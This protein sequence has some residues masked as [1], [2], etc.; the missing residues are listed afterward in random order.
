MVLLSST[1]LVVPAVAGGLPQSPSAQPARTAASCVLEAEAHMRARRFD[2]AI[3]AY[4]L[5][6]RLSPDLAAAHLGLGTAYQ[7]MGRPADA[8]GPLRAAIRYQPLNA[9][10]HLNLGVTLTSLRRNEDALAELQEARRLDPHN[11]KALTYIGAALQNMGRLEEA[12]EADEEARTLSPSIPELHF[13]VGLLL[14]RLGRFAEAVAPLENALRLN[15]EYLKARYHLGNAYSRTNR[16]REAVAAFTKVLDLS[17][18]EPDALA[19]RAWNNVYAGQQGGAVAADARHL[20]QLAGWRTGTSPFM[21]ILA[22]LGYRQ[23]GAESDA[24]AVLSD[25]STR[26]DTR[27]WPYP[28]IRYLGGDLSEAGLLAAADTNDRRTEARAYLGMDLLLKNRNE[29][30]QAHFAWVRDYGN[31]QFAEYTLAVAELGRMGY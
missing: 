1:I 17:P 13:N 25:A 30:A 19:G 7:S 20:L 9:I 18:N 15:P 8:E 26:C 27:A 11:A 22:H 5:A 10:A 21:V 4:Q 6:I 12:L 23:S 16:Y 3:E 2:Q 28:I 29:E 14:M 31:K 24:R